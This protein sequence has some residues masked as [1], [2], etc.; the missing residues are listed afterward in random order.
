MR[1]SYWSK[2]V[3]FLYAPEAVTGST[4]TRPGPAS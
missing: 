2:L 1:L 3:E 4:S